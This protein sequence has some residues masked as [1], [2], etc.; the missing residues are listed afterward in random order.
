MTCYPAAQVNVGI[1]INVMQLM[2]LLATMAK[3]AA[4][5]PGEHQHEVRGQR[6]RLE[7]RRLARSVQSIRYAS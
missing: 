2:A 4:M 6:G 5:G 3:E 1:T 7:K